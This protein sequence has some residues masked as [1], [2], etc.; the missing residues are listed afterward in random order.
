MPSS[1]TAKGETE[2]KGVAKP[3][4][5]DAG[6]GHGSA[7]VSHYPANCLPVP[8]RYHNGSLLDP[9]LYKYKNNLILKNLRRDQ[10]GEYFCKA[11]SAGGSAKSQSAKLSVIGERK[12]A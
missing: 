5:K 6:P 10:S 1:Q 9:S 12:R 8:G 4:W 7:L 3:T 11:S 2:A